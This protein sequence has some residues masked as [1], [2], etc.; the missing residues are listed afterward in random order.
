MTDFL[1]EVG[2]EE[3]PAG[4]LSD[5]IAEWKS[6]I[7]ASLVENNLSCD[8]VNIYGTPR[9]LAVLITGL[10]LPITN[11]LLLITYYLLLIT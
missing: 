7:P 2:T 10:P 9:R 6:F 5:A 8:T 4:F 11:Y 3:L 1:L